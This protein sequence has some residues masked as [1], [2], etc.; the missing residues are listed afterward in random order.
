MCLVLVNLELAIIMPEEGFMG[1]LAVV[2]FYLRGG[3]LD[4][5]FLFKNWS[6][7]EFDDS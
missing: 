1:M 2:L 7:K 5:G 6:K 4:E 3:W